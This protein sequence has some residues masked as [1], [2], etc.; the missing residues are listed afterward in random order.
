VL[1]TENYNR[2]GSRTLT[3][4]S[5]ISPPQ[6]VTNSQTRTVVQPSNIEG[7]NKVIEKTY[8]VFDYYDKYGNL[9]TVNETRILDY[10]V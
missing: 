9:K 4:I 5:P 2:N 3:E 7:E 8:Y 6:I 1:D 10:L